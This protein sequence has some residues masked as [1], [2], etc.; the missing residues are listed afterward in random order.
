MPDNTNESLGLV[1]KPLKKA[2]EEQ[3]INEDFIVKEMKRM[4]TQEESLPAKIRALELM[5]KWAGWN[6]PEKHV[7]TT[8]T[9]TIANAPEDLDI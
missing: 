5:S 4:I 2:L 1:L 8:E 6:Q 3:G 7:V 9:I